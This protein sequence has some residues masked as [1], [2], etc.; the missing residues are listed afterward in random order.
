MG[1]INGVVVAEEFHRNL[2]LK[3]EVIHP[4]EEILL[5]DPFPNT[6]TLAVSV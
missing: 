5:G 4:Q 2:L 6:D 1:D 3:N